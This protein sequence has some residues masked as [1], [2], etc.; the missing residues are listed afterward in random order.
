MSEVGGVRLRD[1]DFPYGLKFLPGFP[2]AHNVLIPAFQRAR[3][4]R[5][6]FGYFTSGVLQQ[7]SHGLASFLERETRPMELIVS[8]ELP[9]QDREAILRGTSEAGAVLS[10]RLSELLLD[11]ARVGTALA[12]H[13]VDCLTWLLANDRLRL[14]LGFSTREG[15]LY[16][17]KT[18]LLEDNSDIV[19]VHGS[20][21]ATTSGVGGNTEQVHVALSW[22]EGHA[23]DVADLV[24]EFLAQW[25]DQSR[26]AR[27][28]RRYT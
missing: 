25:S 26:N 4:V 19:A 27:T 22:L 23:Q 10:N 7:L 2:L 14:R 24:E 16:H 1:V 17:P 6:M 3:R 11:P 15:R 21:N 12:E 28:V 20:S 13:A 18:W 5:G 8:P 9:V